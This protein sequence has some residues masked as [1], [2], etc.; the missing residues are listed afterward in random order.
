MLTDS[1]LHT[2]QRQCQSA[3]IHSRVMFVYE[4]VSFAAGVIERRRWWWCAG[5]TESQIK[6]HANASTPP[7]GRLSHT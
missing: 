1:E 7:P 2:Q 6:N 5:Q 4:R 3:A